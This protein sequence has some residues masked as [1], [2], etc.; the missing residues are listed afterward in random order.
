MSFTLMK[1]LGEMR[2][3]TEALKER[4]KLLEARLFAATEHIAKRGP[5]RPRKECPHT[6]R[7]DGDY[8][9]CSLCGL[10]KRPERLSA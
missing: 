3:E 6:W 9:R 7:A 8:D 2:C 10:Q 4:V 5:G 1:V